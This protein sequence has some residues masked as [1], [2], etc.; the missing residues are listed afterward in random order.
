MKIGEKIREDPPPQ[1][2]SEARRGKEIVLLFIELL[3]RRGGVPS[4][5]AAFIAM[6]EESCSFV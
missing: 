6:R 4:G 2:L 3:I 5:A 1:S